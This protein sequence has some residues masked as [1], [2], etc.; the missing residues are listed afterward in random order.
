VES[1]RFIEQHR[2]T[3]LLGNCVKPHGRVAYFARIANQRFRK[4]A[5]KPAASKVRF[6]EKPL[7]FTHRWLELSNRS[8]TR[9]NL[10]NTRQEESS[11]WASVLAGQ[12]CEF[13]IKILVSQRKAEPRR[14]FDEKLSDSSN[15][16]C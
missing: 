13:L 1:E 3:H 6:H 14:I 15:V 4:F 7:H 8:A 5:T 9:G 11:A 16:R 2:V 10:V 12:R